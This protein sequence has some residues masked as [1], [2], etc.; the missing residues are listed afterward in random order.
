MEVRRLRSWGSV[1]RLHRAG[2]TR[3]RIVL[4]AEE[5]PAPGVAAV[6]AAPLPAAARAQAG[7]QRLAGA[8]QGAVGLEERVGAG[9]VTLIRVGRRTADRVAGVFHP[10]W[11]DR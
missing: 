2:R 10:G 1:R 7:A 11:G 9:A 3:V 5:L 4:P 8:R 6:A